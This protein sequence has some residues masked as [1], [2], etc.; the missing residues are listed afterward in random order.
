[1]SQVCQHC[2]TELPTDAPGGI[3]PYCV[4]KLGDSNPGHANATAAYPG[5]ALLPPPEELAAMFPQLEILGLLGRGGMGVVYKARQASLDRLV[6]L[7]I[8]PVDV[9]RDPTQIEP[10]GGSWLVVRDT[11]PEAES[12]LADIAKHH[13]GMTRPNAFVGNADEV[14]AHLK[15]YWDVGIR[16]YIVGFAHP[17]DTESMK[18]LAEDVRPR[19]E[20]L[21]GIAA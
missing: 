14:A 11:K 2:G 16:G 7:K 21:V 5:T 8:L 15:R 9:G 17:F 13:P 12:V 20:K 3:C 4:L 19:L 10:Y 1:M 6:A 18:R